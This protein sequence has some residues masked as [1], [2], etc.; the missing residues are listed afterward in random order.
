MVVFKVVNPLSV[1]IV[2]KYVLLLSS[3][4]DV[5]VGEACV[6]VSVVNSDSV[7]DVKVIGIEAACE[8]CVDGTVIAR[9]VGIIGNSAVVTV[10]SL[11]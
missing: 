1:L 10:A 7:L 2:E 9:L 5:S 3:G 11:K 6:D 8:D 4:V